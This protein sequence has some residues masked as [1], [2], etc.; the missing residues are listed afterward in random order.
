MFKMVN[1][2]PFLFYCRSVLQFLLFSIPHTDIFHAAIA[3]GSDLE[4]AIQPK[5]IQKNK[6]KKTLHFY[7]WDEVSAHNHSY[8]YTVYAYAF[9]WCHLST[10]DSFFMIC[11]LV[12]LFPF[13]SCNCSFDFKMNV[14]FFWFAFVALSLSGS[15]S[16]RIRFTM[17]RFILSLL[18]LSPF[19]VFHS[20]PSTV[21][22]I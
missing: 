16:Q 12:L 3:F 20:I 6:K 7:Y 15:R 17:P 13:T 8:L 2:L 19:L 21:S 9:I 4:M 14:S 5:Q 1:L 10:L 22:S 11:E 18:C